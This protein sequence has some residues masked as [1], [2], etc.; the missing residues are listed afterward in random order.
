MEQLT[1]F[2]SGVR[3]F[4]HELANASSRDVDQFFYVLVVGFAVLSVWFVFFR[5][6]S[7]RRFERTFGVKVPKNDI[8]RRQ[9]RP[10]VKRYMRKV[11][12]EIVGTA[13]EAKQEITAATRAVRT[14]GR[15]RSMLKS[16]Q[17][18]RKE[19]QKLYELATKF[20]IT[21]PQSLE[22]LATSEE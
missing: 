12:R 5:D 6:V 10:L 20:G 22:V 19:Y 21:V 14:S 9:V 4:F 11:A 8:E 2:S 7:E 18:R 15:A 1:S 3:D 17:V 13:G 16:T